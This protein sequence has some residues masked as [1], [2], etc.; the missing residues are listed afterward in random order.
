MKKARRVMLLALTGAIT[1]RVVWWAIEPLIPYIIALA[2][3]ALVVLSVFGVLFYRS[4]R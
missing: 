4:W 2:S 3:A 1:V